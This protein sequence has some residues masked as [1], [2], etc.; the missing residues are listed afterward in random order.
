MFAREFC[1]VVVL[2]AFCVTTGYGH[3][4]GGGV[5]PVAVD[6]VDVVAATDYAMTEKYGHSGGVGGYKIV[7]A[8]KQ[9]VNGM[10]YVVT[11]EVTKLDGACIVQEFSVWNRAGP[12]GT[13]L[14]N[15]NTLDM[16]CGTIH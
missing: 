8:N 14:T 16:A 7:M 12:P 2:V 10:K 11:V 9:V 6:N 3:L 1:F 15:V 5:S 4:M 13:F